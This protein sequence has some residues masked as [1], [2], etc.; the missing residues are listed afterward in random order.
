MQYYCSTAGNQASHSNNNDDQRCV[1]Q[2]A[3]SDDCSRQVP[4]VVGKT[5]QYVRYSVCP[6]RHC[7]AVNDPNVGLFPR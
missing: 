6:A 2:Q 1:Q 3:S 5:Q 7:R 4:V